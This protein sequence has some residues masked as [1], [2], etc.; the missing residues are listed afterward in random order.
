MATGEDH[1]TP[2]QTNAGSH[3]LPAIRGLRQASDGHRGS[4]GAEF[5]SADGVRELQAIFLAILTRNPDAA[6]AAMRHHVGSARRALLLRSAQDDG[7]H[8]AVK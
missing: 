1:E 7:T 2:S 8:P 4:H 5:R 6:A 3:W